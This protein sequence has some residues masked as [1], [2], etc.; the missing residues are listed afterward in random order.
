MINSSATAA[1]LSGAVTLGSTSS[2][3]GS[4]HVTLSGNVSGTSI[5]LTKVGSNNLVLTGSNNTFTGSVTVN[6]G[7]VVFANLNAENGAPTVALNGGNLGLGSVFVGNTATIGSLS[8][9]STSSLISPYYESTN[10]IKTLSVN[11]TMDGDYAGVIEGT[12]SARDMALTKTGSAKLTLSGSSANTYTGLT[13]LNSGTLLLA[14]NDGVVALAGNV[15]VGAGATLATDDGK[16]GRIADTANVTIDGTGANFQF[17]ANQNDTINTLAIN[18]GGLVNIGGTG[19]NL[20]P[21]GGITSTGGGSVTGSSGNAGFNFNGSTRTVTVSD[22]TLAVGVGI[23]NGGLT[24][25]GA[26]KLTLTGSNSYTGTTTISDGT[27]Q[28]G[29]GTTN[30]S[31]SSSSGITNNGALIYDVKNATTSSYS[32]AISGSGTLKKDGAGT[33]VLS[34]TNTYNGNTSVVAGVLEVDG[35]LASQVTASGVGTTVKGHGTFQGGLILDSGTKLA[36]GNSP[37]TMTINVEDL[38]LSSGSEFIA[39]ITGALAGT[40]YDQV[41]FNTVGTTSDLIL[42]GATLTVSLA[43]DYTPTGTYTL[44][45]GFGSL[46]GSGMFS[47]APTTGST[48][49]VTN[50]M[51][52]YTMEIGY[53]THDITL[54]VIPEPGT[55]GIVATF[56]AAALLRKRRF[57]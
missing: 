48:L 22:N 50:N 31:I 27:L 16:S 45:T 13:T 57:G 8:G 43:N 47:N 1:S 15:T 19:S 54:T 2:V 49:D 30:G 55:A 12:N 24:K 53:N 3:G 56:L 32:N 28:I 41:V 39:E 33:L 4:G 6:N 10:G 20:R 7:Y 5:A 35:S 36:P 29:D 44:F 9:N 25:A 23:N 52:T 21:D 34:G 26:G 17:G 46:S 38:T 14:K 18:N 51:G 11:Q 40:E 37:G 42:N